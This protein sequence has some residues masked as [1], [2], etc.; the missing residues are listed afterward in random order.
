MADTEP[1]WWWWA[2]QVMAQADKRRLAAEI[3]QECLQLEARL[4]PNVSAPR[5]TKADRDA[6]QKF[7]T[8]AAR[9]ETALGFL[10]PEPDRAIHSAV[11]QTGGKNQ[12]V[13]RGGGRR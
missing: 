2:K 10:R 12:A 3:T 6:S 9:K 8:A 4:P 11:V 1:T 7:N 5:K 13:Q